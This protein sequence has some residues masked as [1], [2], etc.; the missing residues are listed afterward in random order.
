MVGIIR[1]IISTVFSLTQGD[2][3]ALYSRFRLLVL[4]VIGDENYKLIHILAN[5]TEPPSAA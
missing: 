1:K 4:W 3:R 5:H 2:E